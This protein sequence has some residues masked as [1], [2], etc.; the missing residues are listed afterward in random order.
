MTMGRS[1]WYRDNH[2]SIARVDVD[3][4][5]AH[6]TVAETLPALTCLGVHDITGG[7][8][9]SWV[10]KISQGSYQTGPNEV[11]LAVDVNRFVGD[12]AIQGDRIRPVRLDL[13]SGAVTEIPARFFVDGDSG[14][15]IGTQADEGWRR[16]QLVSGLEW[17][18]VN[19][20]TGQEIT[21]HQWT[22]PVFTLPDGSTVGLP[23]GWTPIGLNDG[24]VYLRSADLQWVFRIF[25]LDNLVTDGQTY[26]DAADPP[27]PTGWEQMW[28]LL[29]DPDQ[30]LAGRPGG[31]IGRELLQAVVTTAH[32]IGSS[33]D[34][35][36]AVLNLESGL[37]TGAYHPAGRYG[38]LQ[39]TAEELAAAGWTGTPEDYLSAQQEQLPPI[40]AHLAGLGI[41]AEADEAGLWICLHLT[42]Q[43]RAGLDLDTVL[44]APA[45]PRPELYD[46][47]G[48]ADVT[49][50]DQL[51]VDDISRYLRSKRHDARLTQLRDRADRLG[52]VVPPWKTLAEVTDGAT[53]AASLGL[54]TVVVP[55]PAQPGFG[56]GQVVSTDPPAGSLT[57]LAD[58]VEVRVIAAS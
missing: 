34:V 13:A 19:L 43:E 31:E 57:R 23:D 58:A 26:G 47:Y 7:T 16:Y 37:R 11:V 36:L 18:V 6:W 46:R 3:D 54:A 44:A 32:Q 50:D 48:V 17:D 2:G 45:G 24:R 40:G 52:G 51:T 35:L 14:P 20:I 5:G 10:G 9:D 55:V 21:R 49:R 53:S 27:P 42:P 39:L 30:W 28:T 25:D 22:D 4:G 33:A 8:R 1:T 38:L 41:G 15:D 29:T 56:P 12:G